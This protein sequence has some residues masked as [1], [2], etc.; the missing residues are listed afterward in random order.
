MSE[1]NP[2]PNPSPAPQP[3]PEQ[4]DNHAALEA[5]RGEAASYRVARNSALRRAHALEQVAAAHNID[6]DTISDEAL[7]KLAIKDGKVVDKFEY[8]APGISGAGASKPTQTPAGSSG[9][10][11]SSTSKASGDITMDD[12]R[13]MSMQDINNNWAKVKAVLEAGK[14][15]AKHLR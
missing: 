15:D 11:P 4:G 1:N 6:L 5:A 13:S 8:A 2:T 7:S 10:P 14:A 3:T 12:I 9:A